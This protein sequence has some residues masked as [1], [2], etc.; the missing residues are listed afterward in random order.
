[1]SSP[2][3]FGDVVLAIQICKEI[4]EKWFNPTNNAQVKYLGFKQDII[5]LEKR[6]SEL[7]DAFSRALI[8]VDDPDSYLHGVD[9]TLKQEADD[10]L[11]NF[12]STL[13]DCRNLLADHVKFDSKR[14]NFLDNAFWHTSTEGKVNQLRSC[15]KLHD[16]KIRLFLEPLQMRLADHM[17]RNTYEILEHVRPHV[18]LPEIPAN[19]D[20]KFQDALKRDAP[21]PITDLNQIPLKESIDALILH[22]Q[23][24]LI[25]T[26]TSRSPEQYL[27]LLKAH[28]LVEILSRSEALKQ[29]RPGHLYRRIIKQVERHIVEQYAQT[30]I[31]HYSEDA[32]GTLKQSAFAIWPEKIVVPG[33]RLTEPTGREE[34]LVELSLVHQSLNKKRSLLVFRVDERNLRIVESLAPDD[35]TQGPKEL[36]EKFFNLGNDRLVPLYTITASPRAEWNMEI[37]YGNGVA[38]VAYTLKER[39]DAFKLQRAFT[40]YDI[41][42]YSEGVSCTATYKAPGALSLFMRDGQHGGQGEVQL[43]QRPQRDRAIDSPESPR[44]SVRNRRSSTPSDPSH[45]TASRAFQGI[46]SSVESVSQ[47]ENGEEV[48]L[49]SLLP[50]P[51]LIAFTEDNKRYR[52]WKTDS[53]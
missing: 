7:K 40:G 52:I 47:D 26:K 21:I 16:F 29:T 41:T 17:L 14:G 8:H 20:I 22:H 28:W 3:G 39:V 44:T 48:V 45:S 27:T 9:S 5:D 10:L 46:D 49:L 13:E 24:S 53:E 2:I 34:K 37:I 4:R 23:Q 31:S 6:L 51:L 25:G 18:E 43:W 11:G 1:M 38:Q 50:P 15:I 35:P 19:F 30:N 42:F 12:T 33:K 36:K 32:L